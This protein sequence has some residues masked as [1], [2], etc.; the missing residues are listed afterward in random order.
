[1][2][3]SFP[4]DVEAQSQGPA[5]GLLA[6]LFL[7]LVSPFVRGILEKADHMFNGGFWLDTAFYCQQA[8]EKLSKKVIYNL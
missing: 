4:V 8:I 1:M 3:L 7:N 2:G 6:I 5:Q